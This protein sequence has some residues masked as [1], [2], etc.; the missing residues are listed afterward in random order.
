MKLSLSREGTP[1]ASAKQ[2]CFF[3]NSPD[4]TGTGMKEMHPAQLR[5]ITVKTLKQ[6]RISSLSPITYG[7]RRSPMGTARTSFTS[8]FGQTDFISLLMINWLHYLFERRMV[9]STHGDHASS[10][11]LYLSTFADLARRTPLKSFYCTG[12]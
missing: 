12:N 5:R 2:V 4:Q 11:H 1:H 6:E 8:R 10:K 3:R 9:L 7:S